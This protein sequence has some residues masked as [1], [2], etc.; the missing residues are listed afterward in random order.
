MLEDAAQAHGARYEGRPAGVLGDAAAW[1][2]Y[3]TKNLG[4]FGDA[5]A[6]MT[7]DPETADRVR[8][9]RNYG[10][11]ARY[12]NEVAGYNSRLDPVQAAVLGVKLPHLEDGIAA[13][14]IWRRDIE[15]GLAGCAGIA[16]PVVAAGADPVWHLYVIRA[17][18][19][20][21]LQAHLTQAGIETLDPLSD[22]AA[23]VGRVSRRRAGRRASF[24]SPSAWRSRCSAC[25]SARTSAMPIRIGSSRRSGRFRERT[26]TDFKHELAL[27]ETLEH[28]R[29]GRASRRSRTCCPAR[30][31]GATATSASHVL[32]SRTTS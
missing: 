30:R 3:P 24:P 31:S 13:A 14:G 2:F 25:P 15:A 22:S 17:R 7:D 18:R 32:R 1:S 9:L 11:R 12:D 21:A 5:G 16:L 8:V 20:D 28:R 27:V 26:M 10:S 6:V 23:P 4:A 29:S 19:R